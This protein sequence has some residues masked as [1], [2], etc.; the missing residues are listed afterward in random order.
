LI[1]APH[2]D[3][4][5]FHDRPQLRCRLRAHHRGDLL[6]ISPVTHTQLWPGVDPNRCPIVWQTQCDMPPP[7]TRT[8]SVSAALICWASVNDEGA[9]L[10]MRGRY[11]R[12]SG[13]VWAP[14]MLFH[15][16][17]RNWKAPSAPELRLVACA[18]P[19][20]SHR[21]TGAHLPKLTHRP[22]SWAFT[23][24]GAHMAIKIMIAVSSFMPSVCFLIKLMLHISA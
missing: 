19:L 18:S 20:D 17:C 24:P 15:V 9:R 13:H 14:C 4:A 3:F 23:G 6:W 8:R 11:L 2:I 7:T 22:S 21:T 5:T 16:V 1:Y 12:P 10:I